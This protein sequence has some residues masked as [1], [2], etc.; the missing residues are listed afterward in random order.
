MEQYNGTVCNRKVGLKAGSYYTQ[1]NPKASNIVLGST[2]DSWGT[3]KENAD[4]EAGDHTSEARK[5][6]VRRNISEKVEAFERK[7]NHTSH[8]MKFKSHEYEANPSYN[9][10]NNDEMI[11]YTKQ[12]VDEA[13]YMGIYLPGAADIRRIDNINKGR[14]KAGMSPLRVGD[15][16]KG[17]IYQPDY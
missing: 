12:Q 5:S 3:T 14:A 8:S 11:N 7:L 1:I 17:N 16:Y 15:Y 10:E 13:R 4:H 2:Q 9:T 6:A